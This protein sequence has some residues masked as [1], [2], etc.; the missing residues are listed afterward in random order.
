MSAVDSAYSFAME[1]YRDGHVGRS[2]PLSVTGMDVDW[3]PALEYVRLETVRADQR[4]FADFDTSGG[5]VTPEWDRQL[6]RPYVQGV[7]VSLPNGN[8]QPVERRVAVSYFAGQAQTASRALVA[9]GTLAAGEVFEY[10]V[11]AQPRTRS[12]A[13]PS[14]G[15]P[16]ELTVQPVGQ[17]IELRAGSM[18]AYSDR[19]HSNGPDARGQMAVFVPG[20]VL[21]ETVAGTRAAGAAETG[22]ILLG[23][24]YRDRDRTDLFLVVTAQVPAE[25]ARGELASL[26]FTPKAWAQLDAARR[27]RGEGELC[28][29]YWHSHPTRQWC[30]DCPADKRATCRLTGEF[31]S[32]DDALLHRCVFPRAFCV[33]LVV[34]DSPATG[35][36]WPL[37]GWQ[38]GVIAR[39]GF[40]IL[41][42]R[43][44]R[45]RAAT[46]D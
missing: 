18:A 21:R 12:T 19:A 25:L 40:Y 7:R 29:G 22:G 8:G 24:L 44:A 32:A 3:Q 38:R 31:F 14:A 5:A 33:A 13:G 1:L 23:H 20:S 2:D 26:T 34:S 16:T 11:S 17:P 39:R 35:L 4:G 36:T 41:G 9:Q 42:G 28:V 46:I 27:R 30:Q 45:R 15:S 6:G 37:F 43:P 10:V